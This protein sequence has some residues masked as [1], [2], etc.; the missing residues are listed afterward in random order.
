MADLS[1]AQVS[2]EKLKRI[3]DRIRER[4]ALLTA[5][6]G[7][8][9]VAVRTT[10]KLALLQGEDLCAAKKL[11]P[12]GFWKDWCKANFPGSYD[13]AHS[14]MRLAQHAP[15][16]DNFE[17]FRG[18]TDALRHLAER[19]EHEQTQWPFYLHGTARIAKILKFFVLHPLNT[20]PEEARDKVRRMLA[21]LAKGLWPGA[22][23][24]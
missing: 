21:P 4:E 20:W 13:R 3:A 18:L 7:K 9:Y 1:P 12:Y 17:S 5:A 10:L 24:Q 8:V 14:Y 23:I 19:R 22:N 6:T 15:L 11:V 16:N 2:G